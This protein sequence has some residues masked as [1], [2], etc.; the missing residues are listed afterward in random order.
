MGLQAC[1][2]QAR[3]VPPPDANSIQRQRSRIA[4]AVPA[5][6]KN[7]AQVFEAR[8]FVDTSTVG[9]EPVE[10]A[11]VPFGKAV[12]DFRDAT[13]T[14]YG[15]DGRY[16]LRA[17]DGPPT[18]PTL[19]KLSRSVP[20][21]VSAD[22]LT[23][24]SPV[25]WQLSTVP[26]RSAR[27]LCIR[28]RFRDQPVVGRLPLDPTRIVC[29]GFLIRRRL[30]ATAA[31]CLPSGPHSSVRIVFGYEIADGARART[32]IP[33]RDVYDGRP[34]SSSRTP[35]DLDYALLR[36]DRDVDASR[37]PLRLATANLKVGTEVLAVGYPEGLPQKFAPGAWSRDGGQ[38]FFRANLDTYGGSSGSPVVGESTG[39]VEGML[40]RGARDFQ[41]TPQGCY[42]SFVCPRLSEQLIDCQGEHCLFGSIVA[43]AAQRIVNSGD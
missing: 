43:E 3:R 17:S 37:D 28:E 9:K 7:E 38:N 6:P 4:G 18:D 13:A 12:T 27:P 39:A 19:A 14:V 11:G 2:G 10:V 29:S 5:S 1:G 35:G 22:L 20:L 8:R 16:D 26:F 21:I 42:V 41:L 23:R 30:V 15:I 36:L 24:V 25:S 40:V 33:A 34:V 32:L 31:H